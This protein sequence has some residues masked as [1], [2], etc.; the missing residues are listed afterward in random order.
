[1]VPALTVSDPVPASGVEAAATPP[2]WMEQPVITTFAVPELVRLNVQIKGLGAGSAESVHEVILA[3]TC[4]ELV[5]DP[6]RP[7]TNPA[8][9][10]AA[11]R[12]MAI[13]ITVAS[14]GE[15]AFLF[16]FVVILKLTYPPTTRRLRTG[17]MHRSRDLWIRQL[18]ILVLVR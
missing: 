10:M 6:N 1:V 12:V 9:A 18:A 7:N 11:M 15:I 8:M 3:D 2:T 14:T 16:R 17:L 4:A 5:N 13:R